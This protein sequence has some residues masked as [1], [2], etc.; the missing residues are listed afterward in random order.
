MFSLISLL[1]LR[2]EVKMK[3]VD[4]RPLIVGSFAMPS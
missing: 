1:A 2:R 4:I 3:K